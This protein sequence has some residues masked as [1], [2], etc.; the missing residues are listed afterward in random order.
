MKTI[1]CPAMTPMVPAMEIAAFEAAEWDGICHTHA[2]GS[3]GFKSFRTACSTKIPNTIERT[4]LTN[5]NA[6]RS[7]RR[8]QSRLKSLTSASNVDR[9]VAVDKRDSIHI[10]KKWYGT[11]VSILARPTL[12]RPMPVIICWSE[13]DS[14][15]FLNIFASFFRRSSWKII[16]ALRIMAIPAVIMKDSRTY[17]I[18]QRP[19]NDKLPGDYPI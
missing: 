1:H 16:I 14:N 19:S 4:R 13:K 7:Q 8:T 3:V 12:W 5:I 18:R 9:C 11:I 10:M 15:S 6:C 17:F 2:I